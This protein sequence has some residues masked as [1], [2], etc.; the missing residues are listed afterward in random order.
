MVLT[1]LIPLF[2]RP[3][4]CLESWLLKRYTKIRGCLFTCTLHMQVF[5]IPWSSISSRSTLSWGLL[6]E[7]DV[8]AFVGLSLKLG[9]VP[10]F[11]ATSH[12]RSP[13]LRP[14]PVG[15]YQL[16]N[17]CLNP[18]RSVSSASAEN[19]NYSRN[20]SQ[21]PPHSLMRVQGSL[22]LDKKPSQVN[23]S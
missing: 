10:D 3:V 20:R 23:C 22:R 13:R 16:R 6:H 7:H 19:C 14:T 9:K 1:V 2:F 8:I 4:I 21:S 5:M 17:V 18:L 12:H 15:G 11:C